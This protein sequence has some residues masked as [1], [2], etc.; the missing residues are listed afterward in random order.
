[1]SK[2]QDQKFRK[3]KSIIQMIRRVLISAVLVLASPGLC[4]S[5]I[6]IPFTEN[7]VSMDFKDISVKDFLKI[8]SQQTGMNFIASEAVQDRKITLYLDKV[9][10]KQA[11]DQIFK[12][13]NLSYEYDEDSNIILVKDWGAPEV[14]LLTKVFSLKH[15]RV[16]TSSMQEDAYNYIMQGKGDISAA[17]SSSGGGSGSGGSSSSGSGSGGGTEG[18]GRWKSVEESGITYAVKQVLSESGKIMEDAMTNSLIVTDMPSRFPTIELVIKQLD[19]PR[20][21]IMLEVEILDVS[22]NA[23]DK[24]GLDFPES[25]LVM[26]FSMSNA[27]SPL[28]TGFP[29]HSWGKTGGRMPDG[30]MSFVSDYTMTLD[31]LTTLTDTKILARP[32]LLTMNNE[33]AEIKIATNEVIGETAS[34][35]DQGDLSSVTAE[36]TETGVALR[37]TPQVNAQTG[38]IT[39]FVYPKV[40]EANNSSFTS[41]FALTYKD[42]EVRGTKSIVRVKD[43]DT[44][45]IGGLIRNQSNEIIKKLPLLSSIPFMGKMFT[46]KD[47]NKDIQRELIVFITPRIVKEKKS[48]YAGLPRNV[49]VQREQDSSFASSRLS[50]IES[51]LNKLEKKKTK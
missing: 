11:A 19:V 3:E 23:V 40:T 27:A 1:M 5:S 36:R 17:T 37:V 7:T 29:F 15:S 45:I 20:T 26:N 49:K 13:N 34:F 50:S 38:E 4:F 2:I 22:K 44:I 8:F 32:R 9:P 30:Q 16:S 48:R 43:G 35:D 6:T 33:T 42:P 18:K 47:K 10:V 24:I 25:P 41:Q 39:M 12:A 14:E 46:H 28:T 51:E 31:Y 21:Q